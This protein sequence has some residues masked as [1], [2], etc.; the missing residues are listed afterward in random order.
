MLG[1]P[2]DGIHVKDELV[3]SGGYVEV[4]ASKD[5]VQCDS[6]SDGYVLR[7][8]RMLTCAKRAM[9][10][11]PFAYQGGSF[12]LVGNDCSL[13][14]DSLST[15]TNWSSAEVSKGIQVVQTDK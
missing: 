14:T 15:S 7:G 9:T 13:P 11:N 1:A 5:A 12:C 6:L 3:Q 10:A 4:F 8:G 2:K